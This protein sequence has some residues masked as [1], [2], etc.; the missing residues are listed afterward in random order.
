ATGADAILSHPTSV[1]GGLGVILNV[2]NME[3]TLSQFNIEAIHVKAGESIDIASPERMM[4]AEERETLQA[5]ADSFHR[6]F[7]GQV[8]AA[9]PQLSGG[10]DETLFDGRVFTGVQAA[11]LG[12]VDQT[13]YLDDAVA[14]ARNMAGMP[15]SSPV[16]MLRRDNDRAHTLHD[17][18]PTGGM[19]SLFPIKI[20]GMD[21]AE[22]PTFL[23]M[24]Q[25]EPS[26]GSAAS[27]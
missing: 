6:R 12:L 19:N 21:R 7:Q 3:L 22:L 16:I 10:A 1:T 17:V 4:E 8:R 23:Y 14:L 2:Y 11:E 27:Q 25:P 24:W 5:M 20:P 26:L 13:G 9:R 15:E 18:T